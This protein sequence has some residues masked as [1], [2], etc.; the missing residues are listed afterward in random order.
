M[1]LNSA[2]STVNFLKH[3][4]FSAMPSFSSWREFVMFPIRKMYFKLIHDS[5]CVKTTK[6]W[7]L[8]TGMLLN[9]YR[10]R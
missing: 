4:S 1:D 6:D 10:L 3:D 7:V 9:M 2:I 8:R 5:Y